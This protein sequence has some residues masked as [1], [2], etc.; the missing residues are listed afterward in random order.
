MISI[1]HDAE[2]FDPDEMPQDYGVFFLNRKEAEGPPRKITPYMRAVVYYLA[3]EVAP[4]GE[5][6]IVSGTFERIKSLIP[7]A[8]FFMLIFGIPLALDPDRVKML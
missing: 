8:G 1:D 7:W 4:P 6:K 2:K 3:E 5:D